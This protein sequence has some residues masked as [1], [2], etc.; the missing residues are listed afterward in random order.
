MAITAARL[1][2]EITIK[3]ASQAKSELENVGTKAKE[4]QGGLKSVGQSALGMAAGFAGFQLASA[5]IGFL[6][7]QIVDTVKAAL[8]QQ[9][10]MAQTVQAI[11]STGDASGMSATQIGDMADSMTKLTMFSD[12]AIQTSENL[13]LT[14]TNIGKDVFPQATKAVLDLSQ[15]MHQDLQTSSIQVGKALNDPISGLTNLSRIGVTFND[16]QKQLIKTY[17]E[18]GEKAKAQGV[19]LKELQKEF[20]GSAVAAGQTMGGQLKIAENRFGLLKEK[21]GAAVIPILGQLATTATTVIIPMLE[22]IGSTI[23]GVIQWF[24][25]HDA[26]LMAAKIVMIVVAGALV[27]AFVAWAVAAAGAAVATIAATWP[28]LAIGAAVALVVAGIIL[29]VTHWG[30][31]MD[32][33]KTAI[34]NAGAFIGGIFSWLGTQVHMILTAIGSKFQWVGAIF[35]WLGTAFHN[36]GA[37]IGFIFHWIGGLIHSEIVGWSIVFAWI[38]GVFSRI[39]SVFHSII[40]AIGDKFKWLGGLVS[41]VW[42]GIVGAIKG[43]IN[44]VISVI[45]D[46]IR[47]IDAIHIDVGPIHVGFN[48]PQIPYLQ[49]GGY[50]TAGGLAMLHAGERVIPASGLAPASVSSGGGTPQI[51]VNVYLDGAPVAKKLMPHIV[52]EIRMATGAKF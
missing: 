10:I 43:A 25:K 40:S 38:G 41:G 48:I 23:G 37:A 16:T 34:A 47:G 30:A 27:A 14:F 36:I 12:D 51:N 33:I 7:D 4:A 8:D 13:L 24:Q 19:I 49:A 52:R 11:K 15:G 18:H 6:K 50:I 26:A 22:K 17:M 5:G 45:N 2:A 28:I 21:I 35:S 29:A 39:G 44:S 32:W 46:F 42:Q 3:G 9:Q 1:E 20:G 31:I